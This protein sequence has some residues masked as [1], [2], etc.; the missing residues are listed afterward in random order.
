MFTHTFYRSWSRPGDSVVKGVEISGGAELNIDEQIA[1][2]ASNQLVAFTLDISQC[3]GLFMV[4]DVDVLIETNN[5][6]SP[7]NVFSLAA[8]IPFLWMNGD[9]AMRDTANAAVTT[10]ITA[11]YVTNSDV[12]TPANLQIRCLTDPTI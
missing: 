3:K 6:T 10:D 4:S 5:S 2:N 11:I 8:G 7:V 12:D 1:A 9:A